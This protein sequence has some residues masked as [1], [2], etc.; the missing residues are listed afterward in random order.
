[1][2]GK[3][4]RISLE[5]AF[6][7][8]S[9]EIIA[10]PK[11]LMGVE[12]AVGRILAEDIVS[13]EDVPKWPI[14]EVD[15][16]AIPGNSGLTTFSIVGRSGPGERFSGALAKD[17]CIRILTGSYLP[18]GA[19]TVVPQEDVTV[20]GGSITLKADVPRGSNL[21]QNGYEYKKGELIAGQGSRITP[22][23]AAF[24]TYLRIGHI[25]TYPAI[26]VGI[27]SVGSELTTAD[28]WAQG[29]IVNSNYISLMGLAKSMG[30]DPV[31]LGIAKDDMAEISEKVRIALK[32]CDIVV[33]SGGSSVGDTDMVFDALL[34]MNSKRVFRGLKLKPGRTAGV[35]VLD[36]KPMVSIS[37]NIQAATI[38]L[39]LVVGEIARQLSGGGFAV[40]RVTCMI[41]RDVKFNSQAGY[42][43]ILWLKLYQVGNQLFGSPLASRSPMKS[44]VMRAD[45]FGVIEASSLRNGENIEAILLT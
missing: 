42:K 15:G 41:D 24:L 33:M 6:G 44:I 45:G 35:A 28:N 9:R 14:S 31:N 39:M 10:K 22:Y 5:E 36:G 19:D 17:R 30:L 40:K 26:S 34:G 21:M 20:D 37:G 12:S 23:L 4:N 29:K 18:E 1:M 2:Q 38:E 16:Y 3:I 27:L 8:L 32:K 7:L 11:E 13:M 25:M 43:N